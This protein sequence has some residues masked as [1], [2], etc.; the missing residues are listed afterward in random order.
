MFLLQLVVLSNTK[1]LYMFVNLDYSD[2]RNR[3]VEGNA[4]GRSW[5]WEGI[6]KDICIGSK[7]LASLWDIL[8]L[9]RYFGTHI[10]GHT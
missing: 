2:G 10:N 9:I 7:K 1:T 4:Y 8:Q 6:Q 3:T 5:R